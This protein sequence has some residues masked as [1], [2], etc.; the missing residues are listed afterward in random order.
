[1]VFLMLKD[2]IGTDA[3]ERGLRLLWQRQRFRSAAWSDLEAAFAEAAGRPLRDF[4]RQWVE[5]PGA[6]VL[7]L[8]AVERAGGALK[9]RITQ[10]GSQAL[11]VP[12]RLIRADR[13]EMRWIETGPGLRTVTL[14]ADAGVEAVE[15]DPDYRVWR[16]VD[17]ALLPPILR[18][19]FVA[20]RAQAV[21]AGDDPE[22]RAAALSLA[23][24]VLDA[25]P[26]KLEAQLPPAGALLLLGLA[27][28]VDAWL[29]GHGLP[30]RPQPLNAHAGGSAQ[31]Y[32]TV[33]TLIALDK[34]GAQV[35]AGRDA[36]G[37][38]YAV[39]SGRNAASFKA[40]ERALPH[41][42]RQSWLVFDGGR[43]VEKGVWPARAAIV[44][45]QFGSSR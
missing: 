38:P 3:I 2:A 20:P 17:V 41:Y 33:L 6:P 30:P 24:R 44:R 39:I 25:R 15:L 11:R 36:T 40:L 45:V 26:G 35:W 5:R 19:A 7:R 16:R 18:E 27:P 22:L 14:V 29:A 13:S 12:L 37:R 9:L 1:M 10:T 23:A 28:A 8:E 21:L 32:E 43:A 4:F 31:V 42:G 34:A